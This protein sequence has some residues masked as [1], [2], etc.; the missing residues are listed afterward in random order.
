MGNMERLSRRKIHVSAVESFQ[1]VIYVTEE[2]AKNPVDCSLFIVLYFIKFFLHSQ[3]DKENPKMGA[4][5]TTV[6]NANVQFFAF[7]S[8]AN[9]S[10]SPQEHI[11]S[12]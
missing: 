11:R 9:I 2:K 10:S 4:D 1:F 7:I 12:S 6:C 3:D 8:E 5:Y